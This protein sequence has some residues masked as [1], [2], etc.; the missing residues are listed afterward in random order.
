MTPPRAEWFASIA[1]AAATRRTIIIL[2]GFVGLFGGCASTSQNDRAALSSPL[3]HVVLFRG[4]TGHWSHGLDTIA[5][6]L[7]EKGIT[8]QVRPHTDWQQV[9]TQIEASHHRDFDVIFI[10]HSWGADDAI[11]LSRRLAQR[12][13][14]VALLITLDPVTPPRVPANVK[15]ATNFYESNGLR[16][17]LPWWRGVPLERSNPHQ[18]GLQNI[19]VRRDR[20]DL[21]A[22]NTTHGT[23]TES[24]GI[25]REIMAIVANAVTIQAV[26]R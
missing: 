26:P 25:Q 14:S 6:Q 2:Y 7:N 5:H 17:L 23:I 4:F 9:A 15:R 20:P 18:S 1:R 8:A 21:G 13:I 12:N 16:D 10:G 11:R 19:N 3:P 22:A 24:A